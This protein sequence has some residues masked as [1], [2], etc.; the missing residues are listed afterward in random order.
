MRCNVTSPR[1]ASKLQT[2]SGSR[3][4]LSGARVKPVE[5]RIQRRERADGP[6]VF[7]A[8]SKPGRHPKDGARE[9]VGDLVPD[10]PMSTAVLDQREVCEQVHAAILRGRG[11]ASVGWRMNGG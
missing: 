4:G 2:L 8:E 3:S 6:A 7:G 11:G 1:R 5:G 10:D 9:D